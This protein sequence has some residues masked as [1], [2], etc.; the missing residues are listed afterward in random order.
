MTK[1]QHRAFQGKYLFP[2]PP[3]GRFT[4]GRE[5]QTD[6]PQRTPRSLRSDR[7]DARRGFLLTSG[8]CV[9]RVLCGEHLSYSDIT[10]IAR[11]TCPGVRHPSP[12]RRGAGGKVSLPHLRDVIAKVNL[13]GATLGDEWLHERA[14]RLHRMHEIVRRP[15]ME[16]LAQRHRPQLAMHRAAP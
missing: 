10:T 6:S 3:C 4:A 7:G 14:L 9:L 15:F 8:L 5:A 16:H 2:L 12:R 1:Q 11:S 13:P